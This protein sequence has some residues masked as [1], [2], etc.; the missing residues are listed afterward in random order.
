[1]IF[2]PEKSNIYKAVKLN[3]IFPVKIIR[4]LI[5]LFLVLAVFLFFV[6]LKPTFLGLS[7]EQ[8]AGFFILFVLLAIKGAILLGFFSA[9]SSNFLLKSSLADELAISMEKIEELNLAE[10]LDFRLAT[11]TIRALKFCRSKKIPLIT[12]AII[13]Y[14]WDNPRGRLIF[15]ETDL[16]KKLAKE[17]LD[18]EVNNLKKI[19]QE[20]T[21]SQEFFNIIK[22][23]TLLAA[24]NFHRQIELRDFLVIAAE[25]SQSFREVLAEADMTSEDI[26]HVAAWEDFVEYEL[27]K[28]RQFWRLENLMKKRGIGKRWAAG[29]TVNLD[30]YS[31]EVSDFIK[32]QD[33]SIHLMA[34]KKEIYATERIL[35]RGGANNVLLVGRPGVGRSSIAYA[36]AKKATEGRSFSNLNDKRILELDMQAALAGLDTEGEMLERLNIIFSEAVNAGNVILIIDEIHN[37]LGST[38]GPGAINISSVI[39][40]YLSST[41][42]QVIGIT[43]YEGWHKYIENSPSIKNLFVKVEA[44][45]PTPLQTIL[46][47]E[48]MVPGLEKQY[49]TSI[50]YRVLRDIVK[51]TGQYIQNVPFPEKAI[52]ILTEVLVYAQ[53]KGG[54]K[55]LSEYVNKIISERVEVPVGLVKEEERQKLLALE[56]RIHKRVVDQEEAVKLISQAMRRARAGIKGRKRPIGTFLFLGP[57][58]VGKTET[59]KALAEAYFGSEKKMIRFDM[60]EYQQIGSISRL[61]GLPEKEEP[62]LLTKAITDNPFSLLL[63]DEMEKTHPNILNLFLQVF[64][65]G[66]LTDAFGR[67]VSFIDSIIIS[68]SNAGAE[69][70]REQVKQGKSLESFKSNLTDYLLK[71]GIFRPEFLNRFDA[72]VVFR[73]LA[74]E[75]LVK[76]AVLMLNNLSKRLQEG[77]GI[78]LV[79]NHDLVEKVAK[80]GYK[81]EFGARPMRRVIQDKIE[82]RIAKEILEKSLKRGDFIEIKAE[83]I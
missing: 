10:Y 8:V 55:V 57:T 14:L 67:R 53:R 44:A 56:E 48:D 28:K 80:L 62:G 24:T 29:Y 78:R 39:S 32:K 83:E 76:I 22:K 77:M 70:I 16:K 27:R 12:S 43:N 59:S 38:K 74:H 46:I 69:F 71:Q 41:D 58:G 35:A 11:A 5:W 37:F 7:S 25:Q 47:L 50:N 49:R 26:D 42:F 30:R 17:K 51:L 4:G 2:K 79:I 6:F 9:F 1:M 23:A 54:K 52:D 34:H 81:P 40:P 61:I 60:S 72:V 73:P 3:R 66:R 64:D 31:V 18:K 82:S 33:L 19:H 75:D 15:E 63:L 65:E 20:E 13:F 36:F 21:Y 68:T 45:E